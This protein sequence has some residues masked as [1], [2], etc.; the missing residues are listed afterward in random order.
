MATFNVTPEQ[1]GGY[2]NKVQC[3]CFNEQTLA[4]G[5]SMDMPVVFFLDPALEKQE[6]LKRL[7]GVTLSYT[8]IPVRTP[9]PVASATGEN[10]P[11]L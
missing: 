1:F 9:K 3:F 4:P 7:G 5:E 10:E 2:F 8:F 6:T 11:R